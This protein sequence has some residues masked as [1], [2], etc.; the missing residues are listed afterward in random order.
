MRR[1]IAQHLGERITEAARL[2]V[3]LHLESAADQSVESHLDQGK[4]KITG[5]A[6]FDVSRDGALSL[7]DARQGLSLFTA[8]RKAS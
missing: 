8:E 7:T 1:E 5:G 4:L 2:A 6:G 3:K